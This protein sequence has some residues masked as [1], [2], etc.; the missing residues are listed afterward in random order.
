MHRQ[1]RRQSL[2]RL[3]RSLAP[4]AGARPLQ[5]CRPRAAKPSRR[6]PPDRGAGDPGNRRRGGLGGWGR[7]PAPLPQPPTRASGFCGGAPAAL[8]GQTPRDP[9]GLTDRSAAQSTENQPADDKNGRDDLA[10]AGSAPPAPMP[11]AAP[12]APISTADL[13]PT[14]RAAAAEREAKGIPPLPLFAPGAL[15]ACSRTEASDLLVSSHVSQSRVSMMVRVRCIHLFESRTIV[16]RVTNHL[17]ESRASISSRVLV[18]LGSACR[19][20]EHLLVGSVSICL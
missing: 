15:G 4:F 11:D 8:R 1:P 6:V 18:L 5:R 3:T 2:Q 16:V 17:F 13:L 9:P 20:H 10:A 12:T 7:H 19:V 14:Y